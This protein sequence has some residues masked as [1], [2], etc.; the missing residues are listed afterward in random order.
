MLKLIYGLLVFVLL[1][2]WLPWLWRYQLR[3]YF[4]RNDLDKA[5]LSHPEG[6]R[7]SR[8]V[9]ILTTLYRGFNAGRLSQRERARLR[10][11]DDA[12]VYG[13]INFQSFILLLDLV[14][15]QAGE[16]FY[17]LGSGAGKAVFAAAFCQ[18]LSK[19]CGVELLPGL[20]NLANAQMTK[21]KALVSLG[22]KPCTEV[23]L[24]RLAAIQFVN[25]NF[26]NT[27]ISDGTVIFINAT[28]LSYPTWEA[29]LLKLQGLQPGSRVIV[30]TKK[31]QHEQFEVL[32]QGRELMSWG[33]NSVNVYKKIS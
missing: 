19:A 21:A 23:F 14:K 6:K 26:L 22:D 3:P 5:L 31:I 24:R 25:D 17:D 16:V 18:D 28:C 33:M 1:V 9:S 27:D 15:L 20:C 7:L 30:T 11:K 32:Y 29:L 8:I 13:E 12:Y 2:I 4:A 10:L